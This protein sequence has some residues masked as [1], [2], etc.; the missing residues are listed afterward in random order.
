MAFQNLFILGST[1]KVWQELIKQVSECDMNNKWHLNPTR[2]IGLANSRSYSLNA[3]GLF[4]PELT[5]P[6]STHGEIL[7]A[8]KKSGLEWEVV[9]VDVTAEGEKMTHF[10]QEVIKKTTNKIV[11][12]NKNPLVSSMESFRSIASD[13]SRYRYNTSVMAWAAAVP[14]LQ[15]AHGLSEEVISIVGTFSGTLSYVCSELEKGEKLFSTIVKEAKEKGYTEPHP[16]D[17]LSGEDVRKKLMILLRSAGIHVEKED[18]IL[19]WMVDAEKYKDLSAEEFLEAIKQED[20]VFEKRVRRERSEEYLP[21]YIASYK[22]LE[23]GSLQMKVSLQF[24]PRRSE[25]GVLKGTANKILIHTSQRTPEECNA[26]IIESPGAGVMK[27]A[28]SV[29][30]DLFHLLNNTNLYPHN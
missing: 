9:F 29:R 1:G 20:E 23:D 6:Y 10:H 5:T 19:E 8:V 25:F 14:Y 28:A 4:T 21:R 24:V 7:E 27:T 11:T 22:R 30:A 26:H 3:G 18:I 15:E 13:T 16:L 17:D 2:I 12:A